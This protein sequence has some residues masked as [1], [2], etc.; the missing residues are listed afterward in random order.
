MVCNATTCLI[1]DKTIAKHSIE[2]AKEIDIRVSKKDYLITVV[3]E[4]PSKING[5]K[6]I[7]LMLHKDKLE[8]EIFEFTM[9]LST[10]TEDG[11]VLSWY[12]VDEKT[13]QGNYLTID[14]GQHCGMSLKYKVIEPK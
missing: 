4:V 9:P 13:A 12:N 7:G 11:K 14:Y 10:Y 5:M 8:G 2:Y 1:S 3:L 6:F